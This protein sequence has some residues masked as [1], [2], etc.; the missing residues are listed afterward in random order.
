MIAFM[1]EKMDQCHRDSWCIVY[2]Y[3]LEF[4]VLPVLP[5]MKE[6]LDSQAHV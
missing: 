5:S 1:L 3:N 4:M 6:S 2:Y